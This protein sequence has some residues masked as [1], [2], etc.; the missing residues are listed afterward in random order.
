MGDGHVPAATPTPAGPAQHDVGDT[1]GHRRR[2]IL[3]SER[4]GM[5]ASCST[6]AQRPVLEGQQLVV[7]ASAVGRRDLGALACSAGPVRL[8][9]PGSPLHHRPADRRPRRL[10]RPDPPPGQNNVRITYRTG[11]GEQGNREAG[12]IAE[13]KAAVM[14]VDGVTNCEP[15]QGGA[16]PEPIERLKGRGLEPCATATAPS[17]TDLEDLATAYHPRWRGRRRWCRR[18][19]HTASHS[20][21]TPC[22]RPTAR[23]PTLAAWA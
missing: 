13:L 16:G 23:R 7:R 14:Y 10:E 20:A 1:G 17:C 8:R 9:T 19:T 2:E 18:S 15:A 6:T 21:R 5:P 12:V 11:G 4:L 22:R 3:G